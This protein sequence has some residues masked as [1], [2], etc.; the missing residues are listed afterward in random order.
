MHAAEPERLV[1]GDRPN[2]AVVLAHGRGGSPAD[3]RA[4]AEAL[5][6]D[7]VVFVLLKADG[8]V[9]YPNYFMAPLADNE[10][11]LSAAIAHYERAVRALLDEGIG[12]SRIV[13]GGFSQGACLTC[14]YL[15]RHPRHYAAA[16]IFTGGLLGPEGSRWRPRP[17]LAG[18]PAYLAS[19]Q[20]DEWVPPTRARE[21][22]EWFNAS[23]AAVTAVM[24]EDRPHRVSED[25]IAGARQIIERARL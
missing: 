21:T 22:V 14:E 23:G 20:I 5:V 3:M 19:S 6:L 1:V 8:G 17:E 11:Y 9:W 16:A 15:A 7:A 10:P 24:F 12:E 2:L 4:L 13:V 25:E 18:M